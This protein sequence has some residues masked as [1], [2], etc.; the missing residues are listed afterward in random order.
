MKR[1]VTAVKGNSCFAVSRR[2]AVTQRKTLKTSR[3]GGQLER[4]RAD[5]EL[6]VFTGYLGPVQVIVKHTVQ[7]RKMEL[8]V[9]ADEPT[10]TDNMA[11]SHRPRQRDVVHLCQSQ[12]VCSVLS[13]LALWS[14]C[15]C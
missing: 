2:R 8:K 6:T 3:G 15:L 9:I 4:M 5:N 7:I 11:K 10:Q 13:L 1:M 14:S 12:G